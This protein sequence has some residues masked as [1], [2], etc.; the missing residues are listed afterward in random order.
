MLGASSSA[1]PTSFP[2]AL[3]IA[4]VLR[5]HDLDALVQRIRRN[6][7]EVIQKQP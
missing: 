3:K 6:R 4:E 5:P 1:T 2:L 7:V